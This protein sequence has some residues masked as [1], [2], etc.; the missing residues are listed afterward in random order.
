MSIRFVL[1]QRGGMF[2][3]LPRRT[4]PGRWRVHKVGT[5]PLSAGDSR[6]HVVF[7][8]ALTP[9]PLKVQGR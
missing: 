2:E 7:S 1:T 3:G 5:V 8:L 9:D 4:W 6:P